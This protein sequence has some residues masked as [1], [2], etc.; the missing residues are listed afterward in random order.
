MGYDIFEH[1]AQLL[2]YYEIQVQAFTS[3]M[4]RVWTQI[5]HYTWVLSILL[6]VAPVTVMSQSDY[7]RTSLGL[8]VALPVLGVFIATLG[9]LI[10][11]RDLCHM[12]ERDSQLLYLERELGLAERED[13]VDSRLSRAA[14]AH[15]RVSEDL[16]EQDRM[17]WFSLRRLRIRKL[18]L[19]SFGAYV[20]AGLAEVIY[21]LFFLRVGA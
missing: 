16:K 5:Q 8:L 13:Y 4:N 17:Y 7:A 6:C 12:A 11:R 20:L 15:F 10:I 1:P 18:I 19:W 21:M 2:T 14:R 9:F 3:L